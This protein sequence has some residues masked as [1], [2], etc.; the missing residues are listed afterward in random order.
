MGAEGRLGSL[1][2]N[3]GRLR[4][5][6]PAAIDAHHMPQPAIRVQLLSQN[7]SSKT[8]LRSHCDPH[9][10]TSAI[11]QIGEH[12]IVNHV[13][14]DTNTKVRSGFPRDSTP[15]AVKHYC[16]RLRHATEQLGE[17]RRES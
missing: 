4:L 3:E 7:V 2:G 14:S 9:G 10:V 15:E 8:V 13:G 16:V 11:E 5:G 17:K 12:I 1:A 6:A